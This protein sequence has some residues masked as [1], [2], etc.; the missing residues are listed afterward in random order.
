MPTSPFARRLASTAQRLHDRFHFVNEAD[1]ALCRQIQVW[2]EDLGF[3]FT[4]CTAVPWSAVFVS[5]CVKAAGATKTEFKFAMAH[6]VFVHQA[7]QDDIGGIGVFRG[8]EID[9]DVPDVGDIIQH[10]RGGTRFSFSFAR[11]H[12]NY[13]SHSVIVVEIGQDTKGRF[14]LCIGGNE[15][16]SIRRTVIRLDAHGFIKQRDGN[17]FICLV[18]NLK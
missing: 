7:I 4:S 11:T 2:T 9:T 16:D 3:T 5:W 17:P 1:P 10:N 12:R 8:V 6:S 18:K 14:A 13:R 15:S